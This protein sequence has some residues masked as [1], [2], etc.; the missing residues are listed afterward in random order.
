MVRTKN[1]CSLTLP[2]FFEFLQEGNKFIGIFIDIPFHPFHLGQT[3]AG[4]GT[5]AHPAKYI[6]VRFF[7]G[8]CGTFSSGIARY[9]TC[10]FRYN[11]REGCQTAAALCS[12]RV[13]GSTDRRICFRS[14]SMQ[15]TGKSIRWCMRC[16]G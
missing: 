11:E 8:L 2:L 3:I 7:C 1:L 14:R 15:L 6:R 16:M 9:R 5:A 10:D 4:Q 12:R 13:S